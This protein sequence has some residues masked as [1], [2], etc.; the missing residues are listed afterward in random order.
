MPED[1]FELRRGQPG[2]ERH[3]GGADPRDGVHQL[4]ITVAV[5]RQDGDP[6]ARLHTQCGKRAGDA[7]DPLHTLLPS[8]LPAGE[9][10]SDAMGLDLDGAAK[11]L[12]QCEHDGC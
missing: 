5:Q 9:V 1:V 2:V 10:S 3:H 6:V 4:E 7:A 12:G 8:A 11:P